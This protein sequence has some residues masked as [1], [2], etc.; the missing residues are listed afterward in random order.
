MPHLSWNNPDPKI[1]MLLIIGQMYC[2]N[3][4][5]QA[6]VTNSLLNP[7]QQGTIRYRKWLT[8]PPPLD[9]TGYTKWPSL[10]LSYLLSFHQNQ[11]QTETN[12]KTKINGWRY[13]IVPFCWKT[14][15]EDKTMQCNRVQYKNNTLHKQ[16]GVSM[17]RELVICNF[18]DCVVF[19]NSANQHTLISVQRQAAI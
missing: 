3:P 18:S 12:K 15:R 8:P 14:T 7:L 9:W 19:H 5:T 6:S 17:N 2:S 13:N 11:L 1:T 10:T 16:T 4:W